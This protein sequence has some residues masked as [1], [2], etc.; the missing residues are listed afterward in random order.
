MK[1]ING[2]LLFSGDGEFLIGTPDGE[3]IHISTTPPILVATEPYRV[4]KPPKVEFVGELVKPSY[5]PIEYEDVDLNYYGINSGNML[6]K[7]KIGYSNIL[8]RWLRKTD[9]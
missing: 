6:A 1:R 4:L 2:E 9:K 8:N 7:V 5:A 3:L